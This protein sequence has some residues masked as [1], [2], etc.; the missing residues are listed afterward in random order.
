MGCF[1][2]KHSSPEGPPRHLRR[3][4]DTAVHRSHPQNNH[5]PHVIPSPPPHRRVVNSSPKKNRN[6][7]D[8]AP[9]SRTTGVSLRSGLTHGN[10]EA[11]QVAAGWPSW[12]TSAAPEAVHGLVPLRAEDF[13]KREKI[14]QGTYS[15]VFRA[16]E[17]STGRVMALKK[18]RVQNFETEN[19]RFIARE[20]M[21]LRR[22]DHPNI[23]KLE[24]IIASRNSNSMYF[25]FD[26]MEHDLEGLCSSPD[27]KFTEAQIKCYMQQLL[28][29][30]EHCHL[31]GIMHR[32]IKAANILVNNKGVLKIADFGLAN[33]VTPR[34]KNQLTSRVVTLWYR[35]PEL[36]MGSTSYSVSIDLW[37][38]GCVFAEILTGR[39]LLKGRTE[40][41]QL[42]K[43]YKLCGP[44]DEEFWEKNNKLHSQTKMFRPQHQYEGC[45]RESFE[46]F[47]KTAVN[48]LEKLLSTNPEKRGTA[49]SAIMSE[50]FNT[51][52]Y[53]CDPSTL[54]KYPPNKEMDAKYREELQRRRRVGIRKRDNLAPKKSGKSRRT[55]KEPT[56]L[57]KLPSQQE[58]KKEAETE[59]IVQTPSETSQ[60]TTRSEF[61]Y[62]GLSQTTAPASGFAWAGTK[63]RKENDAASTLTYNQPAGSASH[64]SGMSMAFAKNTF[65]LTINED[66]PSFLRPHVSLDSSDALLFPGVHHKK[67]GKDTEL[68]NAGANPKIFQTNGM[69]EI[70]RRTESDAVVDIRRPPR[71]E[72]G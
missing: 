61:P 70:L 47:P 66:K 62:T 35:A 55:I 20:I 72:R 60:A 14:G 16:C 28:L 58:G 69:N 19:I 46:E 54:P 52:P 5:K 29:G 64:V 34:N 26:Y 36:L 22:L 27:I 45:L 50:Y 23:M 40:I 32:D 53:A 71:I 30:V 7:D 25:V 21:I 44:P 59:I 33:I 9:R 43:I 18:I 12:L 1:N 13:E 3:R 2:S 63:K 15:N 56:N 31:R 8:D 39:P 57:N 4:L 10:V 51:K 48:L 37:S 24:G 67:S 17:V 6:K 41:E 42:H 68:T 65:G 11:E 38:V 49:S